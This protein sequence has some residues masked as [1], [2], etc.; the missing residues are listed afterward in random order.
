[1]TTQKIYPAFTILLVDDEEEFLRSAEYALKREG[2]TNVET[3]SDSRLIAARLV[4]GGCGVCILDITMPFVSGREILQNI[5]TEHPD[6]AV[7]MVTAVN[8]VTSAVE[9]MKLGAQDYIL[10][11][12]HHD[13]LIGAVKRMVESR[14]LREETAALKGYI[15]GGALKQPEAFAPLITNNPAM[16]NL[17]KYVEAIA[18]TDLPLIIT[19]ETGTG[20][21][22]LAQAIH[23]ASQRKGNLV[24]VNVAGVDD[25][26]F[27]DTL[28]GHVR[29]A[30]TG[31]DRFRRGMIE[32]AAQGTL[33]LDEIGD[34]RPES[35]IKLLRLLQDGTFHP[36]GSDTQMFSSARFVYATNRDL[37]KMM[38]AGVFRADLYYRLQAHEVRLPPL[39]ERPEDLK[40]LALAFV[41][42]ASIAMHKQVPYVNGELFTLLSTYPWPGNIRELR[43]IL[44]DAVSRNTTETLSLKYLKEKFSE[45]RGTNFGSETGIA[46]ENGI[47]EGQRPNITFSST[48]PS[49]DE[50]E[51]M[52]IREALRRTNG[53]KS[54]AA[55]LIG[56][57][58]A[59]I[60][61]RVK[62]TDP[63]N[64]S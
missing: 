62:E 54:Q 28:F 30:F 26:V 33:F 44:F 37:K 31:A 48:L 27:S 57:N 18:G 23:T 11:P 47:M 38:H 17:F 12:L 22:L 25:A 40:L 41:E 35:Q 43:G 6:V 42:E 36:V 64:Q 51:G 3:M 52:L 39:R 16:H 53:N 61:K 29:G 20:K 15:L 24:C 46:A 50:L 2:I 13:Q 19:G 60:I 34:L 9:C 4:R 63:P 58:R 56:L 5:S 14:V 1:M 45:L 32:E 49:A 55:D 21:E 59:T 10:K 8:D 7:C